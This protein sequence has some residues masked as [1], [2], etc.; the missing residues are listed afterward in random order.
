[1]VERRTLSQLVQRLEMV[2]EQVA[3]QLKEGNDGRAQS[4]GASQ[5][6]EG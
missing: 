4:T 1:M 3:E 2:A 6:I 5:R